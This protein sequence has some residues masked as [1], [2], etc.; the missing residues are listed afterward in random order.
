MAFYAALW[1]QEVL[2]LA[3]RPR[4]PPKL[5]FD[6]WFLG[7]PLNCGF[8]EG[9][10]VLSA[11]A[12]RKCWPVD[13]LAVAL[14]RAAGPLFPTC[15]LQ[16][17]AIAACD[18]QELAD[19]AFMRVSEFIQEVSLHAGVDVTSLRE[20]SAQRLFTWAA[21]SSKFLALARSEQA[22]PT[23]AVLQVLTNG[24]GGFPEEYT[25]GTRAERGRPADFFH[26]NQMEATYVWDGTAYRTSAP[27]ENFPELLSR[28]DGVW[29]L[30]TVQATTSH[31]RADQCDWPGNYFVRVHVP[32][33]TLWQHPLVCA[34][35]ELRPYWFGAQARHFWT[36]PLVDRLVVALRGFSAS[37]ASLYPATVRQELRTI[38][39][40]LR[41]YDING[42]P[43]QIVLRFAALAPHAWPAS[44]TL[45]P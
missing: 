28:V 19:D 22:E 5:D 7:E 42:G 31:S 35:V 4:Y 16:W 26:F 37:T 8:S 2:A 23:S 11:E 1:E 6:L 44:P 32:V 30:G 29:H 18:A 24:F 14:S 21:S 34:L 38:A 39:L 43:L 41:R 12:W 36:A 3:P 45:G 15:H 25:V 40:V 33:E 9:S 13:A 10:P 17:T 20:A 27:S